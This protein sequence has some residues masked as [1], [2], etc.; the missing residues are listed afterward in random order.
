MSDGQIQ[1]AIRCG[2][3]RGWRRECADP[4]MRLD[5]PL[6]R[7]SGL[8]REDLRGLFAEEGRRRV[9]SEVGLRDV[10]WLLRGRLECAG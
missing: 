8:K 3:G 10:A 7:D 1:A 4:P 2:S 5:R 6:V 9:M